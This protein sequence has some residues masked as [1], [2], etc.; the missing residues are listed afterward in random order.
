MIGTRH[1][2]TPPIARNVHR[3][4]TAYPGRSCY[5]DTMDRQEIIARLQRNEPAL[6]PVDA[7]DLADGSPHRR[8]AG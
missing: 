6:P 1:G 2:K 7:L 3:A 5:S 4:A 8:R